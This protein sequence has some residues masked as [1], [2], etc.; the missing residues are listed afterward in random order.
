MDVGWRRPRPTWRRRRRGRRG[1]AGAHSRGRGDAGRAACGRGRAAVGAT[2]GVV[3]G[4]LPS[5]GR[6][7]V[8]T[9]VGRRSGNCCPLPRDSWPRAGPRGCRGSPPRTPPPPAAP[10]PGRPRPP[11]PT[12]PSG[13]SRQFVVAISLVHFGTKP[14]EWQRNIGITHKAQ[15]K[16]TTTIIVIIISSSS[17]S[18]I[19]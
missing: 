8:R 5:V 1:E 17:Q 4:I 10:P 12:G 13:L 18:T 3:S 2:A 7:G 14:G 6:T 11:T 15:R 9:S 19:K 16:I